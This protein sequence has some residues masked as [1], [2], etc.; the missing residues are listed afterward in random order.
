[1]KFDLDDVYESDAL[2]E[3]LVKLIG[4]YGYFSRKMSDDSEDWTSK[5]QLR[6]IMIDEK[7]MY[8]VADTLNT[9]YQYFLP[10]D[11]VKEVEEPKYRPFTL[12]EFNKVIPMGTVFKYKY[13]RNNVND[14]YYVYYHANLDGENGFQEIFFENSYHDFDYCF[15]EMKLFLNGKWQPFGVLENG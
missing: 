13:K 14:I 11:K 8:F 2:T 4:T 3:D 6:R 5:K 10:A 12:E 7:G 15:N 9:R 1:M